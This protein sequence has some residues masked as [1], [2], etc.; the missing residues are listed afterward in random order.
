MVREVYAEKDHCEKL[1]Q[2]FGLVRPN[3]NAK[4]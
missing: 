3:H 1:N 4:F 2:F